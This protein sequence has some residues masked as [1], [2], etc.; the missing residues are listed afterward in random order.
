MPEKKP[1]SLL[2]DPDHWRKSAAEM[3]GLAQISTGAARDSFVK[4][5]DEYDKLAE[6]AAARL[7]NTK[8]TT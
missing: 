5:A 1:I 8:A 6:R 2:S 3:R 7:R 4:I